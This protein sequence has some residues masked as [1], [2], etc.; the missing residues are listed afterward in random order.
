MD[1]AQK[2]P[3]QAL[4]G[5]CRVSTDDQKLDLQLEAMARAGV[6]ADRIFSD[7]ASG[8]T[9][10]RPGLRLALKACR[11]GSVLLVWKMDRLG[12]NLLEVLTTINRLQEGGVLIKSLTEPQLDAT[13]PMGRLMIAILGGIAQWERDLT[14]E[15]TKAGLAAAKARGVKLGRGRDTLT[16]DLFSAVRTDIADGLPAAAACKKHGVQRSTYYKRLKLLGDAD[17]QVDDLSP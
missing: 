9:L 12:R 5:Y 15:R 11:P 4:I 16:D 10:K 6:P 14:I 17:P 3:S 8:S 1:N 2:Q 7:K 13:T